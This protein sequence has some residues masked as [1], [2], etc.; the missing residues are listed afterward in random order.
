[1]MFQAQEA[2]RVIGDD[3]FGTL[4]ARVRYNSN[5]FVIFVIS[6]NRLLS[7]AELEYELNER[8]A[9]VASIARIV[10]TTMS[11]TRVNQRR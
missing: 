8:K 3:G 11:S 1:M 6:D 10:I 2:V 7:L 4:P 9:I 5:D